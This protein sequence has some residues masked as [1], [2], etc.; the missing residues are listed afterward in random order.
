ML[1]SYKW[2]QEYVDVPWT[3]EALAERLT[4]SGL[5]VEGLQ[6]LTDHDLSGVY[7]GFVQSVKP[8]PNADNLSVCSVRVGEQGSHSIVCGAPNVAAGQKVPVA[9]P[10]ACLPGGLEI[11]AVEIRGVASQGMICSEVELGLGEDNA[12]IWVLPAGLE[13]G[14][15]LVT[16]LDLDDVILDVSIYAN[17][18]DCMSMLGIAREVAALTGGA[19]RLPSV[20]YDELA[21][22]LSERTSIKVED[23]VL[24]PRYTATLLDNIKIGPSPIWMQLRL[25]AAGMR[26]I[27][28]VVDVT[29]YVMLETGQPLHAFDYDRLH[30]NRLI[31]RTAKSNEAI[32]TLDGE[33]RKLTED[34]LLICDA[35][36]PKCIAGIMGGL[37]SEV[38]EK[39]GTILLEA[40][41]FASR[42]IR[43]TSR[44]LGLGSESSAR[45]EKGIDPHGTL[46]ASK[47]AAH[48]LQ[49]VAQ[50]QVYLGHI[51]KNAVEARKTVIP[52][53]LDQ[54]EKLLGVGVPR[55]TVKRILTG[56]EFQ[57]DDTE[58][59]VWQVTVPSHRGDVEIEADLI[60]EIVRIWGLEH[61]PS[62]LP[63][64]T[65]QSGG[66]SVR[67]N[68]FD[69]LRER[70]M[71]AGLN[72][73]LCYSFGRADNNDRL[74]RPNQPMLQV[75][76]PISEDLVALRHSL[77]P[78]LLTAVGL[79]ASRQQTRV[80]LFE[81]GAVYLGE[82]PVK[83]QPTEE[84]RL[85]I[86][87]WGRRDA[88]NW[89]VRQEDY[90]FYDLKGILEMILP[91]HD[92]LIWRIG[93]NPT[94]HPGRQGAICRGDR[95]IAYYGEIHPAVLRS[96]RIPGR[97]YGAELMIEECLDLFE[98]VPVFRSLPRYPA[99]ERDLALVV[100]EDQSVGELTAY[101]KELGGELLQTVVPFD[102]Y[103]GK[104]I[105]E[106]KKSIAFSCRFQGPRTLV[107]E[108]VNEIMER[109]LAG[110]R[111]RYGAEIR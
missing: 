39:S 107:D 13:E 25:R 98:T 81:I 111:V 73:A 26:P 36:Q 52:L 75:Q 27:N 22:H 105:P 61:L 29:N 34:M 63:A 93:S 43:R 11:S 7:V 24:C 67:L 57:V 28:N 95:E 65:A 68:V 101:L 104:P 64:D 14:T 47:R 110:L 72:E 103:V 92:S 77:L 79:N 85:G 54:I 91:E 86:V 46:F 94:L 17:R 87:L 78:G 8:H 32:V 97:V 56:L 30:E 3:P 58:S 102:V 37:D 21:E 100:A 49:V 23:P 84:F 90:D 99:V 12:G 71:G 66:Q 41:N 69:R 4:M 53:R 51:D 50:A 40:A 16:A 19:V 106:G 1:V 109:C 6:P 62:L 60:E 35:R 96:F 38:T 33:K 108:E 20:E 59:R 70:L 82:I 2:L 15:P 83:Q 44:A 88:L 10:G 76:N 18:P 74:L 80:A 5:E 89:G 48:L 45:F 55:E 31:I 42:S 9:L